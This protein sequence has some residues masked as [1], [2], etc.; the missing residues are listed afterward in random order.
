MS[1]RVE[2]WEC[3][4]CSR[5][6]TV[7]PPPGADP[8]DERECTCG[9]PMGRVLLDRAPAETPAVEAAGLGMPVVWGDA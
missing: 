8:P 5:T 4:S 7:I 2:R 3:S 1:R 9:A 6:V